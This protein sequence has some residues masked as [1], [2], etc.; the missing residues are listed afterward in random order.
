MGCGFYSMIL[1]VKASQLPGAAPDPGAQGWGWGC[2][3]VTVDGLPI[4]VGAKKTSV[5]FIKN[6][7]FWDTWVA[8]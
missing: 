8:Q 3:R 6:I 2:N 4:A 5:N 1:P 7:I